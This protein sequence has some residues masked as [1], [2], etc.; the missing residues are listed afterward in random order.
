MKKKKE[1]MKSFMNR[2]NKETGTVKIPKTKRS[3]LLG[4]GSHALKALQRHTGVVKPM[5]AAAMVKQ[6]KRKKRKLFTEVPG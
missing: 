5:Q 6:E 1:S 3:P 2:R 4:A